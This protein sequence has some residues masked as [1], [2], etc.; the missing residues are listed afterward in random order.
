MFIGAGDPYAYTNHV[1]TTNTT[2]AFTGLESNVTYRFAVSAV[3][4]S[5]LE[6]ELSREV[7][8]TIPRGPGTYETLLATNVL[9]M[10]NTVV[11]RGR[12]DQMAGPFGAFFEVVQSTNMCGTVNTVIPD[13]SVHADGTNL[14]I[15]AS[16]PLDKGT[17]TVQLVVT[18][19]LQFMTADPVTFSTTSVVPVRLRIQVVLQESPEA[20]GTNWTDRHLDEVVMPW[21]TNGAT[22]YRS[23]M[24]HAVDYEE[25]F[26]VHAFP[27]TNEVKAYETNKAI[28]VPA[29]A[30]LPP[31]L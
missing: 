23:K 8:A 19:A 30:P 2:H 28:V 4:T 9:E 1:F 15:T 24:G 6:S 20:S 21:P 10:T 31:G 3:S 7:W 16:T 18:N 5:G 13:Q 14:T 25:R 26:M 27:S 29:H 22:F 12:V 17:Y 11:L